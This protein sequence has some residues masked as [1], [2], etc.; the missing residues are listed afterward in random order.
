MLTFYKVLA[1]LSEAFRLYPPVAGQMPRVVPEGGAMIAGQFVPEGTIVSVA[2][3]PANHSVRNFS[4]PEQFKPERFLEPE[5]F[6]HD[7]FDVLQPFS[8]GPRNCIGKKYVVVSMSPA[9]HS[10]DHL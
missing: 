7:D 3:W 9:E 4:D 1:V 2:Q 6:A 8:T 10:A 5:K